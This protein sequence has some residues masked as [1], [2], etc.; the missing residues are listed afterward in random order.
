MMVYAYVFGVAE[1]GYEGASDETAPQVIQ[2]EDFATSTG[3]WLM[4]PLLR[5]A[6]WCGRSRCEPS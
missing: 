4:P 6:G 5:H 3:Y 1:R 2:D